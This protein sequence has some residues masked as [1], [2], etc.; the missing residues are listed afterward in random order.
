[1]RKGFDEPSTELRKTADDD[2]GRG[3]R[4]RC[5]TT[6]PPARTNRPSYPDQPHLQAAATD[7]AVIDAAPDIHPAPV[8]DA[9]VDPATQR[10]RG[11]RR[12]HRGR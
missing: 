4:P 7:P 5:D 11:R 2:Q 1:M 10:G 6:K 12:R 8:A 9:V 3:H